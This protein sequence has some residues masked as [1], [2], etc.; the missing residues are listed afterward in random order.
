MNFRIL[1]QSY[2]TFNQMDHKLYHLI[3]MNLRITIIFPGQDHLKRMRTVLQFKARDQKREGL[4]RI[5]QNPKT[6]MSFMLIDKSLISVSTHTQAGGALT[7]VPK[8]G[9]YMLSEEKGGLQFKKLNHHN[10]AHPCP[11]LPKLRYSASLMHQLS[12]TQHIVYRNHGFRGGGFF[13][14]QWDLACYLI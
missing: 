8:L 7:E 9:T 11:I 2:L 12:I 13:G 1:I 3:K 10:F 6:P 4:W 5:P 14:T